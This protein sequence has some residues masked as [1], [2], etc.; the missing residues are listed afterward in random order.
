[1]E[2]ATERAE[3]WRRLI[4][5]PLDAPCLRDIGGISYRFDGAVLRSTAGAS[6]SQ[7]Q[8]SDMFGFKWKQ[9]TSFAG[10]SARGFTRDWLNRRYGDVQTHPEL[11][12]GAV[13][14]DAGCGAG[15][16]AIEYFGAALATLHYVGCDISAAVDEAARE[17]ESA[18]NAGLFL[19]CD[20]TRLPILPESVDVVFSEGV[21]HHTDSTREAFDALARTIR[22]GGL[23]MFYVYRKKGPIREFTDD[24]IRAALHNLP[25]EEAWQ[26]MSGL[27]KL[28][29]ALGQLGATLDVPEDIP[30]LGIKA[31]KIDIQ[32]FFYW[33]VLK[34]FYRPEMTE[35]EMR[36]INFDW[37]APANAHRHTE[38]E[39]RTWCA[40]AGFE[41]RREVVEDAGITIVAR[42]G[43]A[44]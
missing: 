35:D 21:M 36:H 10:V 5:V 31:G 30:L 2:T 32:R 29:I 3:L 44:R 25:P 11:R 13:V 18:G 24:Y 28:G 14:L 33:N 42:R 15:R 1:M 9:T 4:G 16:A 26:Q 12:P 17:F 40:C 43:A 22:P 19:Q 27:T 8:T 38:A 6:P 23:F 20:L 37:Y 41:I 7:A 34:A 39:I